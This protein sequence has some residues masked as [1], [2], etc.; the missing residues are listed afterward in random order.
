MNGTI[1][2]DKFT[3]GISTFFAAIPFSTS[4]W[5][6]LLTLGFFVWL[7]AKA[8]RT[9]NNIVNWEHLIVDSS[10]DRA[11]PY[12]LGYLIGL[13]VSTWIVIQ[14]ADK[15]TLSFDILGTY[16]TFLLGGA[17]VNSFTK[18]KE[19]IATATTPPP[20]P[21]AKPPVMVDDDDAPLIGR[22]K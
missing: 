9:P 8:S 11:S 15:G 14:F 10:N 17:G 2:M 22:A 6:V 5:F 18:S 12:K 21:A 20:A 1:I 19:S 3:T 16:L 13:I 4:T 7:F